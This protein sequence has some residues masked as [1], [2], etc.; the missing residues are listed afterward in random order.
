M[1]NEQ[2]I[3]DAAKTAVDARVDALAD[4]AKLTVSAASE[5]PGEVAELVAG[6]LSGAGEVAGTGAA[7]VIDLATRKI[8]ELTAIIA[9]LGGVV[10]G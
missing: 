3:V 9:K 6:V 1:S 8:K 4:A 2:A 10:T 5:T 7:D